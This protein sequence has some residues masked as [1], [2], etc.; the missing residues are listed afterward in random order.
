MEFG[1]G[2]FVWFLALKSSRVNPAENPPPVA[3]LYGKEHA[4]STQLLYELSPCFKLGFMAANLAILE[5]TLEEVEEEEQGN[6]TKMKK[7]KSCWFPR[8]GFRMPTTRS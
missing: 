4:A 7:K 8:R 6:N 3:E 1:A 5:S 2:E